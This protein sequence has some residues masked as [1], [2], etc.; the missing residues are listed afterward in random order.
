MGKYVYF[1]GNGQAEGSARLRDLLGGKGAGLAEM[2]NAGLPVPPGFTITTEAC[3]IFYENGGRLP[4]EIE[5]EIERA[6]RR[7]EE[8]RGERLGD[9]ERPL[10]VSVRSGA[11]FSMPGMMDT[12]LNLGLNDVTVEA[13][14]RRTQ[15]PRFAYDCYR[16]FVQMFGNV[17]LGVEK[18]KFEERIEAKKRER[19]VH[20]DTELTAE[21]LKALVREFKQLI[22]EETGKDFPEDPHEQL[23]QARDA[24]FRSW[25]N[26]RAITYRQIHN[27][28]HDLGTAVNV[29]AMVFG[30][31]GETS[32]SGVG[33]TRNPATGEKELF[34]EFLP[35]AQGEDVVAGIRTPLPL[36]KLRELLPDVYRQL[37]E[38]AERL[39]R[40]YRDV[41]DFEFTVQEGQLFMLQTRSA[42][43]TGLAA[44]KIA[45]D[46]VD[47]GLVT[48]EESLRLIEAPTLNQLLHPTFDPVRRREFRVIGRGLASSP[49]AAA[50]R[51]AFTARRA[52]EMRRQGERVVL[53]RMETSPDDI[54]GMQASEGFLT[55]RGGATSHAAVV[56]RQMGKPAVVGCSALVID[57]AAG[58]ARLGDVLLREGDYI[59]IDGTT[60]EILLGD[61]PKVESEILRVLNGELTPEQSKV[62]Q[63]F[64]RVMDTAREAK[65]LGVRANADTPED[66][67][68]ARAFG[69]EGIGLARTEHMFFAPD[70]LPHM[71][72]MILAATE[73]QRREALARLLPMQREDFAAIFRAMD[74]YPV[75]IRLLDPPLH[76]F[77]PKREHLMVEIA[78]MKAKGETEGLEEKERLLA[79]VEEL[80]EFNPMLGFRGCRLGILYPEIT[81]MQARA[82]FEAACQVAREG[83]RVHPEIMVP[84]VGIAREFEA[85]REIID[86]V[87][88]E[89]MRET[90]VT[91]SYLVGTMIELPRAALTA[92]EIARSAEFFSF[93]TNDLTQTTFG[94]SR[95]DTVAVIE[96]YLSRGILET[97]PF[98]I[99]D[100]AGVGELMKIGV[101]RG[102][103]VRADLKTGIC[104]EHGG[105]PSSVEFCH[106]IGLDYVSCSPYRVPIAIL[107]AAQAAVTELAAVLE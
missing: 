6:L 72:A 75:T 100:R 79:R 59:S 60:G 35:N 96:A 104:G 74:G 99:L 89:V 30:N 101:E 27:I 91:I 93:G 15:N 58:V 24:V 44:I 26:E 19:G 107:A 34:G 102:R 55:A 63:Y 95:D 39:E 66:A 56:G 38:I 103:A 64:K 88:R 25:N 11:K 10:L 81:E 54:A 31:M 32:G 65:R 76:E 13:L 98:L 28:P 12:I 43:R 92:G 16:R 41:Q 17:V 21:D 70:R 80:H 37:E 40:H 47:E 52:V 48:P 82:I 51:I 1:F 22:T 61:V 85:Q 67:R 94:F 68:L 3:R 87:A 57:E 14:A 83:V 36:Q 18:R 45:C 29:Q 2:T 9:R 69:A 49:G 90:G 62:Y 84:L 77:L 5:E 73:A 53:V 50:G 8:L 7:L 42:K 20:H 71:Q 97:D 23:V 33:F 78:V 86:R 106:R 4:A 46:M 105:E